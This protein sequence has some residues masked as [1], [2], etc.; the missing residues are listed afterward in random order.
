MSS[1]TP[2]QAK[3]R[4]A[5][6]D[7]RAR[8]ARTDARVGAAFTGGLAVLIASTLVVVTL[9]RDNPVGIVAAMGAYGVVLAVLILWHRGRFRISDR[10]W[11][12]RYAVGFGLTMV[13]YSGGIFWETM[14]FPGWAVFAPYCLLVA[15]PGLV[16]AF[17]MLRP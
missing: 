1:L 14:A 4:L 16:A 15:A 8:L 9:L 13:L 7:D 12:A 11:A 2:E 6:A 5:E 3:Q 17:R 10:K